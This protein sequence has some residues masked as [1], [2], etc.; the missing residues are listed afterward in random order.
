APLGELATA[1]LHINDLFAALRNFNQITHPPE[2][3]EPLHPQI[4]TGHHISVQGISYAPALENISLDIALGSRVW[5]TGPSGSGKSTLL[6]LLTRFDDPQRGKITLGG[7]ALDQMKYE[8]LVSN[9]A[10]VT[11]EPILFTGTLAENIRLG[12]SDATDDEIEK[13]ARDAALG[14]MID[15][16]S[17]GINQSVGKQGTALSGGERQR[18]AIARAL[19]KNAPILI[20]D[21]AT[22]ALDEETEQEIVTTIRALSSTVIFVTHRDSAIWQ[23]TQTINLASTSV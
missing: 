19:L 6:E 12:K 10:Y 21:E 2:L 15:R 5:V 3:P 8:D 13:A 20:L 1:G 4:L 7:I 17:E 11:Q 22:S 16:S 23:P 9:I 14:A 18:V